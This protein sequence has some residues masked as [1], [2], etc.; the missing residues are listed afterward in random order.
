MDKKSSDSNSSG[1]AIKREIMP[2]QQLAKEW[3]K[4]IATKIEKRKYTQ[5]NSWCSDL[6]D[7]Q[8]VSKFD[9]EFVFVITYWYI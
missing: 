6:V 9:K 4:C 8:F 5:D 1:N 3:H 2:S 7:M